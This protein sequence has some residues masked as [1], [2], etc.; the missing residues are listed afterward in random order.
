MLY[1]FACSPMFI[2]EFSSEKEIKWP[3]EY[4]VRLISVEID[5][6]YDQ[7]FRANETGWLG[8]DAATSIVLSPLK[9]LWLFGDTFLGKII[10]GRRVPDRDYI[11][12]CIVIQ[13]RKKKPAE[14]LQYYWKKENGQDIAFFPH[15][16][17]T[18]GKY[19]WATSGIRLDDKLLI[20]CFSLNRDWS[21]GWIAGTVSIVIDNPD[22]N[23]MEWNLEYYDMNLGDD[24]FGIHSAVY[25]E[26]PWVYYLGYHDS[27]GNVKK[28]KAILARSSISDAVN[29]L[30]SEDF[31]YWKQ[32]DN[33]SK[34]GKKSENLVP[35]FFPGNTETT[36]QYD[37]DYD[38]YYC[39]TYDPQTPDILLT[40]APE[41]TGPWSE[42]VCIYRNPNHKNQTYAAK[43]H[44]ELSEKPGELVIS[45]ITGPI[46]VDIE[47]QGMDVY[48]P[49]F[50]RV[51]IEKIS[52]L[53]D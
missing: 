12:N 40:V 29:G 2:G 51:Q 23:P 31:E 28:R 48:R 11:N 32:T 16:P 3:D 43:C 25:Y 53:K 13:D 6:V 33:G 19:Y 41:L 39:T 9:T 50:I 4:P 17:G 10:D 14:S 42:P 20:F 44:P 18:S 35:L 36:I 47:N 22:D 38:L 1:N 26:S 37:P 52:K 45:F 46:G 27:G 21:Q 5:S 24:H 30:K 49:R 7:L 34:W 15:F 8:S